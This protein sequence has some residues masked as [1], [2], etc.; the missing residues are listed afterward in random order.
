MAEGTAGKHNCMFQSTLDFNEHIEICAC[1]CP[2]MI[3]I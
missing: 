2:A 1:L 3:H